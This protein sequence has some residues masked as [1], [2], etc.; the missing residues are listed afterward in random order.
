MPNDTAPAW[1]DPARPGVP[2]NPERTGK[3]WFDEGLVHPVTHLWLCDSHEWAS[4]P[5]KT[6]RYIGPC[7][8]P[9]EVQHRTRAAYAA[10]WMAA[11]EAGAAHIEANARPIDSASSL[12][13]QGRNA[14]AHEAAM[15]L[16]ALPPPADAAA[17]LAEVVKRAKEEEREAI[18]SQPGMLTVNCVRGTLRC[19]ERERLEQVLQQARAEEREAIC[20]LIQEVEFPDGDEHEHDACGEYA[21]RITA[22]IRARGEGGE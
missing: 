22:A 20:A 4:A 16:R 9:Q 10:G 5:S 11:R 17:A 3:H 8:T 12:I 2:M 18:L 21:D 15:L 1:P 6:A 19:M 7:L 13:S 14:G